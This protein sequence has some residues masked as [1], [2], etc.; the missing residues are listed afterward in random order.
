MDYWKPALLLQES[1]LPFWVI[2]FNSK[3]LQFP[4]HEE[5]PHHHGACMPATCSAALKFRDEG[6]KLMLLSV[7]G[8]EEMAHPECILKLLGYFN[9]PLYDPLDKHLRLSDTAHELCRETCLK[10]I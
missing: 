4:N 5:E 1:R 2:D 10:V 9:N 7:G 6:P 3:R 8:R